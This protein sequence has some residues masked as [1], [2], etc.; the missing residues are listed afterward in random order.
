MPE[1]LIPPVYAETA[2]LGLR[3]SEPDTRYPTPAF[4]GR[5]LPPSLGNQTRM[6]YNAAHT[7]PSKVSRERY[8]SHPGRKTG[9]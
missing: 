6:A 3:S 5:R 8:G 2:A 1:T 4:Q 7:I 9:D